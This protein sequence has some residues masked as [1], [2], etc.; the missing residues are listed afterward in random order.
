MLTPVQI[1]FARTLLRWSARDLAEHASLDISTI[2]RMEH[3][4]TMP[5][6]RDETVQKAQAALEAAGIKFTECANDDLGVRF[7]EQGQN[8]KAPL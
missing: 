8:G 1:R 4:E 7:H 2:K 5:G 6:V 3:W